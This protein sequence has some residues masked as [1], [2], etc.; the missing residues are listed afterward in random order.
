MEASADRR[1]IDRFQVR[2]HDVLVTKDSEEPD[3]IAI[4]AL[5][6]EDLPGVLCGYHLAMIRPRSGGIH[7]PFIA[8][9]HASKQF[10][11]Q[12]EAKAVGVTRFGLSQINFQGSSHSATPICVSKSG[13]R[14]IWMR[15]VRRLTRRLPPNAGRLKFF[16]SCRESIIQKAVTR[17]LDESA[18]VEDSPAV[19]GLEEVPSPWE[20]RKPQTCIGDLCTRPALGKVY[21]GTADRTAVLASCQCSGRA[22]KPG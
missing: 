13:L 20:E 17:G 5:V 10:R 15:V 18:S 7:G 2:R 4:A 3:D 9:A 6:T 8:W 19:L 22:S 12:Y 21:D 11:A 1:E 16:M 14:P